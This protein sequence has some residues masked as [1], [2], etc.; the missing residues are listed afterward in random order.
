MESTSQ[1]VEFTSPFERFSL[2]GRRV[3][4][5][6]ARKFRKRCF[7]IPII[8]GHSSETSFHRNLMC[9]FGYLRAIAWPPAP[10]R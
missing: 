9:K 10:G 1:F 8:M 2:W 5:A 4:I 3:T 6:S 7:H